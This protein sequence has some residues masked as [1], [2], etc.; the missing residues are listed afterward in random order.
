MKKWTKEELEYVKNN[1]HRMTRQQFAN[2]FNVPLTTIKA[3]TRRYGF[4]KGG[5]EL[6]ESS[7]IKNN[8]GNVF[9]AIAFT[10]QPK[11]TL[12]IGILEGYSAARLKKHSQRTVLADL[13]EEFP[14]KHA[15]ESQIRNSFP[16]CEIMKLDFYKDHDLFRYAS[17]DLMHIDIANDGNTYRHFAE[18]YLWKIKPGGVAVL[19]GGSEERDNYWWMIKFN[20][21]KISGALREFDAEGIKY[22]VLQPFPS[23]TIVKREL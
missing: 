19:E 12:E 8:Y 10:L 5:R 2:Y 22:T 21:P 3:L 23:V 16:D 11:V 13:F 17:I 4:Q 15:N 1:Y 14:F 18:Q 7:Y 20:R 9:E 6:K